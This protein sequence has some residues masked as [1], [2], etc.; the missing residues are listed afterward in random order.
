MA[1]KSFLK[2]VPS[3][4]YS[5]DIHILN[6]ALKFSYFTSDSNIGFIGFFNTFKCLILGNYTLMAILCFYLLVNLSQKLVQILKSVVADGQSFK[7]IQLWEGNQRLEIVVVQNE[8][9]NIGEILQP[10]CIA[11]RCVTCF[12]NGTQVDCKTSQ[13]PIQH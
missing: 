12:N 11:I 7:F 8:H 10:R 3:S 9:S 4:V 5:P 2:S 1:S 13:P 6:V